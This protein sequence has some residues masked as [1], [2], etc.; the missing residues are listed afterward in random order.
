M[1]NL[2]QKQMIYFINYHGMNILYIYRE[3]THIKWFLLTLV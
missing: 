1:Q 2:P 3:I